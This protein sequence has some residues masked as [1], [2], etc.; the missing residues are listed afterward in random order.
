MLFFLVALV[1]WFMLAFDNIFSFAYM[2]VILI[3]FG[4]GAWFNLIG[5]D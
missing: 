2:T 4:I 5:R 1:A 3:L